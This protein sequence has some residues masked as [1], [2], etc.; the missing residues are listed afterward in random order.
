M[1]PGTLVLPFNGGRGR[2]AFYTV[3]SVSVLQL[4]FVGCLQ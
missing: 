4:S 1:G 3:Y 2:K